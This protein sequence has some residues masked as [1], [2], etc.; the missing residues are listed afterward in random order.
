MEGAMLE[1]ATMAISINGNGHAPEGFSG[2]LA[3][4]AASQI[5]TYNFTVPIS[6]SS[7]AD[8]VQIQAAEP[9]EAGTYDVTP[10]TDGSLSA[11]NPFQLLL[12][13]GK[14]LNLLE[15]QQGTTPNRVQVSFNLDAG[16]GTL[17]LALPVE[18]L[19]SPDGFKVVASE[20][21]A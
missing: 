10:P 21:L 13:L 1:V 12:E 4:S 14:A 6:E 9:T 18:I 7:T 3:L 5:A 8:F 20:F 11:T 15:K 16:T 17:S 2:T 19:E